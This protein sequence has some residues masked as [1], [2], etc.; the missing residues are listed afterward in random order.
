MSSRNKRKTQGEIGSRTDK[1]LGVAWGPCC[2]WF[3]CNGLWRF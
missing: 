3:Q 1:T 2:L